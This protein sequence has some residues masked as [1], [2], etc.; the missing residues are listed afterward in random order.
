MVSRPGSPHSQ[1]VREGNVQILG[2]NS[3]DGTESSSNLRHPPQEPPN[4]ETVVL[5]R[6]LLSRRSHR[7]YMSRYL[8]RA[9]QLLEDPNAN[10]DDL[11]RLKHQIENKRH[12]IY[13]RNMEIEPLIPISELETE[14]EEVMKNLEEID[15]CLFSLGLATDVSRNTARATT[16][17]SNSK[18][19][20]LNLPTF[21]GDVLEFPSFW[22][23]FEANVNTI[24]SLSDIEKFSHLK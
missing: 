5:H 15:N 12:D 23:L 3:S 14:L 21:K 16:S 13:Q 1:E 9:E 19:P 20:K 4:P 24:S 2:T 6:L 11:R 18:L 10:L 7:G 8:T 17:V 22:E